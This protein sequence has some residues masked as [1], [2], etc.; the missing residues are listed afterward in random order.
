KLEELKPYGIGNARPRFMITRAEIRK[1]YPVGKEKE[2][3]KFFLNNGREGIG[4][5]FGSKVEVFRNYLPDLAF[6]LDLNKWNDEEKIQLCLEDFNIREDD[7]CFPI[8][9][10]ISSCLYADNRHCENKKGYLKQMVKYGRNVAVYLNNLKEKKTIKE[11]LNGAIYNINRPGELTELKNAGNAFVLFTDTGLANYK[12]NIEFS[13]LVFYSLPFSLEE[14]QQVIKKLKENK[15]V[16]HFLFG[17]EDIRT[18]NLLLKSRLPSSEYLKKLYFYLL[19][20]EKREFYI[21]E[22]KKVISSNGQLNS[23]VSKIQRSIKVLK[24]IGLME[25]QETKVKL[26]PYSSKRLDLSNSISYNYNINIINNY[27]ELEK[28]AMAN[29]LYQLIEKIDISKNNGGEKYNGFKKNHQ[30][31]T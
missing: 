13:D 31:Y 1:A 8:I 2:H 6:Y 10:N 14:M 24:E 25:Q 21:D 20:L 26:L 9:Y 12:S 3:L 17:K 4:F 22:I 16:I 18:N 19:S 29:D 5:D 30:G 7:R 11:K 15:T 27:R 28:V 23:S